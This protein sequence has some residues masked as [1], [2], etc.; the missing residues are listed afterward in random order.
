MV[1]G[2]LYIPIEVYPNTPFDDQHIGVYNAAT[3][4]FVTSYN[5][6]AQGHEAASFAYNPADGYLYVASFEDGTKL[7][8]Y[9][10]TGT[11]I[12]SIDLSTTIANIQGITFWNGYLWVNARVLVHTHKFQ[13]NGTYIGRVF[14]SLFGGAWEGLGHN[15]TGLL[16]LNDGGAT[17]RLHHLVPGRGHL[18]RFLGLYGKYLLHL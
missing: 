5:I 10:L 6:S 12:G 2:L 18:P 9:T 14:T 1:N 17:D 4:N 16:A 7:W 15:D 11:Y 8:K 3:L 13:T